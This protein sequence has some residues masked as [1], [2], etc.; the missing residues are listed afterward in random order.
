MVLYRLQVCH[1]LGEVR[2]VSKFQI[3]GVMDGWLIRLCQ[4]FLP[5][6]FETYRGFSL[7]QVPAKIYLFRLNYTKLMLTASI[8]M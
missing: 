2:R 6:T 7:N 5:A 8:V 4:N 1:Y 3:A